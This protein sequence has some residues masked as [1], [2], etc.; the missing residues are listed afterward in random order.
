MRSEWLLFTNSPPSIRM[1]SRWHLIR[2]RDTHGRQRRK[3]FLTKSLAVAPLQRLQWITLNSRYHAVPLL[4]VAKWQ[5]WRN[6]YPS[7]WVRG[8]SGRASFP[9]CSIRA[10][11]GL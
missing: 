3:S 7:L 11:V 5:R 9:D 6:E 1:G 4:S 2:T 8:L 10:G